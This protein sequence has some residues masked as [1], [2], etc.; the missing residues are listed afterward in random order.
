MARY[1]IIGAGAVGATTAVGL[2]DAGREVVLVARGK[3]LDLL[4]QRGLRFISPAGTRNIELPFAGSPDEVELHPHDVLVLA[5][6]SQDTE[7]ALQA[8][9]WRP[10]TGRIGSAADLLPVVLLQNGIDNAR[11]ALRRFATVIDAV[12]LSPSSFVTAG[13]V[14]SPAQPQ[15]GALYLG[16]AGGGQPGPARTT[17]LDSIAT[18]LRNGGYLVQVVDEVAEWKAGKLLGNLAYNLDALFAPS[19]LRTA[20]GQALRAEAEAVFDAA[21]IA[22]RDPGADGEL[23]LATIAVQPI[24]GHERPGSST[25]QSVARTGVHE[26]DFLSG[27]IVLQARLHGLA[28]PLNSAVQRWAAIAARENRPPASFDDEDLRS[29]LPSV[30]TGAAAARLAVLVDA[31]RLR[32]ELSGANPP[33]LLD[34]RWALGDSHGFDHYLSGHLPSA[35]YVDLDRE[36]ADPP[37]SLAGRHPLPDIAQLTDDARRWGLTTGRAVVV[38]DNA[39]GIAAARAWW[40]LRW[41]GVDN[42][43]ILNGTLAA[44]VRAGY[45]LDTGK[46][47]AARGDVTLTAGRLPVLTADQAADLARRG[48]LID[49]RAGERYRGELEPVDSRAGHIPGAVSAPTGNNLDADG[50]FLATADLVARFGALGVTSDASVGVY[51][52]SGVTAAHEIAA[53]AVAGVEAAL[54]PGSWSAWS[55]DPFRPITTGAKV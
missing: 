19:P 44:W 46:V 8:W 53:L 28:A 21:G 12:V 45:K 48:L 20:A 33:L 26:T 43:R 54:Y 13:E 36:L 37:T 39:G 55:A 34:V 50:R 10:V 30:T 38:Y 40:L 49:A 3:H 4:K 32:R 7:A 22:V 16:Y 5:T 11:A 29:I 31:E 2:H 35:V 42:V 15:V 18:D 9:A 51:C 41:G 47:V 25:W 17:A 23:D 14:V 6:K 52:G 24:A 27:E 1:V